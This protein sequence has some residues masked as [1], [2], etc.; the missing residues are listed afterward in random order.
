MESHELRTVY[1]KTTYHQHCFLKFVREE[2]AQEKAQRAE[3]GVAGA[4]RFRSA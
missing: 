1:N 3:A 2:A 4:R